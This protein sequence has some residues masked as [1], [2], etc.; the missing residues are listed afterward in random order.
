MRND[1][2][3][4]QRNGGDTFFA[5]VTGLVI[6]TVAAL[7]ANP[8]NREKVR[9]T[10]GEVK[11]KSEKMIADT[12]KKA[13]EVKDNVSERARELAEGAEKEVAK[14]ERELTRRTSR[15]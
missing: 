14:A 1:D 11:K 12:S 13:Q 15:N 7:M 3:R 8:D 9:K 2:Y 4:Y 6:G 10:F 5:F